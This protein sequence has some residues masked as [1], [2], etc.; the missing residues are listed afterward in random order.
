[1]HEYHKNNDEKSATRDEKILNI[2][3]T[4]YVSGL[5]F[6]FSKYYFNEK[7]IEAFIKNSNLL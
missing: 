3:F 2:L 1:M 4:V 7:R 5:I 6:K